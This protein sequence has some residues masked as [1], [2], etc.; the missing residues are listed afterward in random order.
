[1]SEVIDA[2]QDAVSEKDPEH[3][4]DILADFNEM[5]CPLNNCKE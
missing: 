3:Y 2:V 5:G 4:K 1:V